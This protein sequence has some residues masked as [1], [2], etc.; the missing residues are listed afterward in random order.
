VAATVQWRWVSGKI[1]FI[2]PVLEQ[3]GSPID[4]SSSALESVLG[5]AMA[6]LLGRGLVDEKDNLYRMK[7][8][9]MEIISYYA[10]SIAHWS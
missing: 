1:A 10:N 4:T 6:A 9:E 2:Q 8:S 5:S 3:A 7:A